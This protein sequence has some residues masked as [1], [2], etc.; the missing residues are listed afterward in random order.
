MELSIQ[1]ALLN[2]TDLQQ[3]IEFYRDVF[4]LRLVSE[5]DRVA[6]LMIDEKYRRQVL[7]LRELGRKAHRGG[8][9]NV[10]VRLL[11]FEAGS[12]PELDAI[13]Q[14]LVERQALVWQR[15]RTD[16]YTAIMG[17]DPDRIEIAVASSNL[18]GT[19]IR[20]ED[21]KELDD[22]IYAIE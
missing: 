9:G 12:L 17:V 21:W 20:S 11:S 8:R 13:E 14:R 5:G 7:V 4:N 19:P 3:S 1:A 22:M 6:A 16:G 10:G 18:V 15:L 2:V